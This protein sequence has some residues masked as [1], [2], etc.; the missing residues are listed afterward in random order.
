MRL[1][2][3]RHYCVTAIALFC[4]ILSR[5]CCGN[6]CIWYYDDHMYM[7]C[8]DDGEPFP[9][10]KPCIYV[11]IEDSLLLLYDRSEEDEP[12]MEYLGYVQEGGS[13]DDRST[14]WVSVA[15]S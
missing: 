14:R 2:E 4:V 10:C 6:T 11:C 13:C 12:A 5:L 3:L 8:G 1:V 9:E 15:R 7:H